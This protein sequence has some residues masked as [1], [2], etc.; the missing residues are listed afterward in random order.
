VLEP[1]RGRVL[2]EGDDI[3]HVPT[4]ERARRGIG[5]TFQRLE[6]FVGMTVRENLQVAVESARPAATFRGVFR[7]RH[8]P[9]PE[10]ESRVDEVLERLDL[11]G[12]AH[13]S[14]GDLS[15]GAL[16]MV[17]LGR[18]MCTDP[19][20]LLLDELA[21]GL[22]ERETAALEQVLTSLAFDGLA[23][24]LIEHDIEL[25]MAI[26]QTIYVLDFG[27][28]LAV[29]APSQVASDPLVRA[30]YIGSALDPS[31]LRH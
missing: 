16:R 7:V 2:L 23:I 10:I 18:A 24:L 30:A 5:R 26:S 13:R 19:K 29:G 20:I 8:R 15:T 25:V 1:T 11:T 28:L 4:H 17:E 22:D 27:E 9:E 6:I 14:A 3:T 31:D 12:V 21:S